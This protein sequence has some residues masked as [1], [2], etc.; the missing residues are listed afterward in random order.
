MAQRTIKAYTRCVAGAWMISSSAALTDGCSF[1]DNGADHTPPA[2]ERVPSTNVKSEYLLFQAV[3]A[4]TI[5]SYPA[6]H[7]RDVNT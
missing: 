7:P 1:L 6:L 4:F 2:S 3:R 5:Y